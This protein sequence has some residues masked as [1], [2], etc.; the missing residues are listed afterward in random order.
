[1]CEFFSRLG[2]TRHTVFRHSNVYGPH[3]KFDLERSHVLGATITKTMTAQDGKLVVWG[4]GEE[5]RDLL[6]VDDLVDAV[7]R[8]I[9]RQT[10][11]YRLYN[12]GAGHVVTIK[13]LVHKIV[14][15]SGLDLRIEHDLSQPTIPTSFSLDCGKARR[16][17]GWQ[18]KVALDDGIARTVAW[19]RANIG[20]GGAADQLT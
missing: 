14:R 13:D 19:W 2:V 3:D 12:I 7:E 6:Y 15:A 17:L 8:A 5:A 20:P 1:M 10:E 4:T 9:D 18:P 11:P 16:E